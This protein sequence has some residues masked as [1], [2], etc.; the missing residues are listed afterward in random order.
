MICINLTILVSSTNNNK[1]YQEEKITQGEEEEE[2]LPLPSNLTIVKVHKY[3]IN[4]VKKQIKELINNKKLY[5]LNTT[6]VII[7][8]KN[9]DITA[10]KSKKR[11]KPL[12]NIRA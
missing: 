9:T 10:L 4:N 3:Y 11:L 2:E 1:S 5:N 12:L 6:K 7:T 8:T